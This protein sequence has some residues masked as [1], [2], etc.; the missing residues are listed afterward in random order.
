MFDKFTITLLLLEISPSPKAANSLADVGRK[1]GSSSGRSI[2]YSTTVELDAQSE[3]FGCLFISDG[4]GEG[5]VFGR[6]DFGGNSFLIIGILERIIDSGS[7]SRSE[8]LDKA[9]SVGLDRPLNSPAFWK[10]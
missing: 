5:K 8:G 3:E 6:E 9:E 4:F 2:G 1:V 7:V 10:S